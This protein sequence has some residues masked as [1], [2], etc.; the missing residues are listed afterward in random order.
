VKNACAAAAKAFTFNRS[1]FAEF[2]TNNPDTD[3]TFITDN[4]HIL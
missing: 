4:I 2:C 1:T 3:V